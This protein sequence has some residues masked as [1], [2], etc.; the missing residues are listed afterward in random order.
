VTNT[1]LV[2]QQGVDVLIG[3]HWKLDAVPP[4]LEDAVSIIRNL[5][6][7]EDI[8]I[9]IAGIRRTPSKDI[10]VTIYEGGG[11]YFS[12]GCYEALGCPQQVSIIAYATELMIVPVGP[13][14]VDDKYAFKVR[15]RKFTGS[16]F[17]TLNTSLRFLKP[18]EGSAR[19]WGR[20]YNGKVI[21][22]V[23]A[24]YVGGQSI[25]RLVTGFDVPAGTGVRVEKQ[26]IKGR[27]DKI[28]DR[29]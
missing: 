26:E 12:R 1:Q 2:R 24:E 18:V 14:E 25:T 5:C 20:A 11:V 10:F 3:R 15:F 27:R 23:P 22:S 9:A 17:F 28:R 16:Y 29:T 7:I 8:T 6:G 13:G 21:I 4:A 19:L